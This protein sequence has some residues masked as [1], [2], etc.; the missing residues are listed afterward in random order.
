[1]IGGHE[2][3]MRK[4]YS[5]IFYIL[6]A[7]SLV[8]TCFLSA[9]SGSKV[10]QGTPVSSQPDGG[11][12]YPSSPSGAYPVQRFASEPTAY[13]ILQPAADAV[14][15]PGPQSDLHLAIDAT[16]PTT[17]RLAAGQVQLVEFFA[18]WC[19][20]C[21]SLKPIMD[22]T[23]AEYG[24]RVQFAYLDIDDERNAEFKKA[25]GFQAQP[26]VFLLGADGAVIQT[27]LGVP[28]KD[29]LHS[30]LDAALANH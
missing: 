5:K 8:G 11:V 16:D 29:E 4:S 19:T 23:Q 1:M 10:G 13:P 15:Y 21:Q 30:A 25:L 28:T 22:E 14:P 26:H 6:L 24:D 3:T 18:Y 9:C 7:I 12:A 17:F 2:I 27:W 20:T